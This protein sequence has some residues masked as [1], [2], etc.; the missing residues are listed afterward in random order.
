MHS[1]T[2]GHRLFTLQR[3][4]NLNAHGFPVLVH[5]IGAA[6]GLGLVQE[7]PVPNPNPEKLVNV[8]IHRQLVHVDVFLDKRQLPV[9]RHQGV[10]VHRQLRDRLPPRRL[11]SLVVNPQPVVV[12]H[13]ERTCLEEPHQHEAAVVPQ[14][15][16]VQLGH[17]AHLPGMRHDLV[18]GFHVLNGHRTP[19]G[20]H[21]GTAGKTRRHLLAIGPRIVQ[22]RRAV[23][24]LFQGK[25]RVG[26]GDPLQVRAVHGHRQPH[27]HHLGTL[28]NLAFDG[29]QVRPLQR[30][31]PEIVNQIVA[32]VVAHGVQLLGVGIHR[33]H[34]FVVEHVLAV[35]FF[36]GFREGIRR[37]AVMV[38]NDQ[39]ARQGAVV[40]VDGGHG[41]TLFGGDFVYLVR[42]N[43]VKQLVNDFDDQRRVVD[44]NVGV[45]AHLFN[46]LKNLIKRDDFLFA[47]A[48]GHI[49]F[50]SVF[51]P[52]HDSKRQ[53][54]KW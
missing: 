25:R 35:Q 53:V 23:N 20:V 30:L 54:I 3:Q 17:V 37:V 7:I 34:E 15:V 2:K 36:H 29:Q 27:K 10:V 19:H 42:R 41:R 9:F 44:L 32:A 33:L 16:H 1:Q 14:P 50:G 13:G 24:H 12:G 51:K 8:R 38:G 6:V 28:I 21:H 18:T 45:A 43:A 48:L 52:G 5:L 4:H 11:R 39:A 46:T 47:V 31:E 22:A 40:V 26:L 49:H